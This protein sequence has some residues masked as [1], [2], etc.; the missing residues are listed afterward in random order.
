MKTKKQTFGIDSFN[1]YY[2]S[3]KKDIL[4]FSIKSI[5]I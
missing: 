2:Q 3:T 1:I 4:L 5:N